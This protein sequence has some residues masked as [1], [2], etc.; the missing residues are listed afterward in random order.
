[1]SLM[2]TLKVGN[3]EASGVDVA[4]GSQ[5]TMQVKPTKKHPQ[6]DRADMAA[7]E[8]VIRHRLDA[9]GLS[10]ASVQILENNRILVRLPSTQDSL[11][12]ARVLSSTA[13]LE[14]RE[15]KVGTEGRLNVELTV[16]QDANRRQL[17]LNDA[18]DRQ[19]AAANRATIDRQLT[20]IDRLFKPA[21][22][23][24]NQ[25]KNAIAQPLSIGGWE[26][27]IEFDA[28]GSKAFARM[29]KKLAGTGRSIGIFLDNTPISTPTVGPMFAATGITG[30]KAVI[31]GNFTAESA[32]DL[33]IQIRGGSLPLP[34]EII[35]NQ[36]VPPK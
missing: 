24:G 8:R 17:V 33:S 7:V 12:V 23:S 26:V 18:S 29:T 2:L 6:I 28:A 14:F 31:T 27:A 5:L 11:K 32:N 13:K 25:L 36:T 1:M 16:L 3:V 15:Q 22:I 4:G 20:E 34:V 10:Q 9:L 30:G 35:K 21:T 19:A